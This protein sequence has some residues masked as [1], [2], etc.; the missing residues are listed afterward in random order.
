[1]K[2]L[3]IYILYTYIYLL[4]IIAS[5][6]HFNRK[7]SRSGHLRTC[8]KVEMFNFRFFNPLHSLTSIDKYN[9]Q[10]VR[11]SFRVYTGCLIQNNATVLQY[12]YFYF[13]FF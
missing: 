10:L 9:Y 3:R 13:I 8:P 6:I 4:I 7:L 11:L 5:Y 12:F 1:M 2:E